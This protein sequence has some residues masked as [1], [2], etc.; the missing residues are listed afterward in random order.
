[1]TNK[2]ALTILHDRLKAGARYGY[3]DFLRAEDGSQL[4]LYNWFWSVLE[5]GT[6]FPEYKPALFVTMEGKKTKYA[7]GKASLTRILKAVFHMTALEFMQKYM[8]YDEFIENN[9][10]FTY[11]GRQL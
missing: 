10:S 7:P 5:Y 9:V 6:S 4:S 3:A 11:N 1:M 2:E 8:T